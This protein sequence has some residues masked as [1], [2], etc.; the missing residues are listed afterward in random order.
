MPVI[1]SEYFRKYPDLGERRIAIFGS[2]SPDT[3]IKYGPLD[4]IAT[5][6][7]LVYSFVVGIDMNLSV[8]QVFSAEHISHNIDQIGEHFAL[9]GILAHINEE[10]EGMLRRN[11]H[12]NS[13]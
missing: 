6:V 9:C 10:N 13:A 12:V 3:G 5:E 2:R 8:V 7:I 4:L 1:L 11:S